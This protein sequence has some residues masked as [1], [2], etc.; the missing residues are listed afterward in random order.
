MTT[1]LRDEPATQTAHA[2]FRNEAFTDFSVPANEK[3][4]KEAIFQGPLGVRQ[5]LPLDHRQR[6]NRNDQPYRLDKPLQSQRSDCGFPK[7]TKE[8]AEKALKV[9]AETFETWKVPAKE[10]AEYIFKRRQ[11]DA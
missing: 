9:A 6:E 7:A 1:T 5:D 10:R 11:V 4:M 8:H 2:E 3:A